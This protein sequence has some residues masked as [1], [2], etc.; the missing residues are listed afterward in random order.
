M[1]LIDE[2]ALRVKAGDGGDG[3]VRF[4]H[5]KYK[6]FAGPSGGD[7]GVGGN[8]SARAVRDI[9]ALGRLE[10]KDVIRA[11]DGED[12]R[13]SSETGRGG[14]DVILEVPIGTVIV[15]TERGDTW[16]LLTEGDSVMLAE[17]G[18][19]GFGNEH[20]KSSTNQAPKE[21]QQGKPGEQRSLTFSLKLIADIGLVGL[22]NVGKTSLLNALT[23][24]QGKTGNYA[25]TTLEPSLGVYHGLVIADIPG[26]IEGAS[27]G[28]G[29]G[30]RFLKHISRTRALL[31]CISSERDNCEA[32]HATIRAELAAFDEELTRKKEIVVL[33][34]SDEVDDATQQRQK[35][36]LSEL[37]DSPVTTVS[38]L[39]DEQVRELGHLLLR[40]LS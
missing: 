28:K 8:V 20:F 32:D 23:R 40:E 5:E 3:V 7:G 1:A 39:D 19:G 10:G 4:R 38:V 12:G 25:F 2:I 14:R 6:E 15:D 24:A 16:E 9:G 33:T 34:R 31:H 13:G 37:A 11:A 26:L 36:V 27:V 17:G 35:H 29:L 22:P 30:T 18:V 21:A